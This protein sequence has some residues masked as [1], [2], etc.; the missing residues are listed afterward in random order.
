VAP[1]EVAR[2]MA[3]RADV[4]AL[5]REPVWY[6]GR[7]ALEQAAAAAREALGRFHADSP[8]RAGMPREELRRR[9]LARAPEGAFEHVLALLEAS[10][11]ARVAG[12]V[13]ALAGHEVRLTPEEER[14]RAALL[15]AAATAGLEGVEL[16]RLA[17]ARAPR[18]VLERVAKVLVA[19]GELRRVGEALVH[20]ASLDQLKA[21]VR[22]RWPPGSRLDVGAF[23]DM[24]GLSRKYTIPLL[25][26]LDRERVTRRAGN[27]RLVLS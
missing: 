25:E 18:P 21:R 8:L 9:A 7:P 20:G 27:D 15:E 14:A 24:T 23:K 2:V 12:E 22:E 26:Y 6:V 10:G 3:S 4:V 19:Q 11:Q 13:V 16:D 5:G 17:S 1:A